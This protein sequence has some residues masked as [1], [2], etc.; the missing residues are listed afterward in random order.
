MKIALCMLRSEFTRMDGGGESTRQMVEALRCAGHEEITVLS[1]HGDH[2]LHR[3]YAAAE[4]SDSR[5]LGLTLR[6]C[7]AVIEL[8]RSQDVI[9]LILPNP[10]FGAVA[11][12]IH[13]RVQVPVAVVYESHWNSLA[14]YGFYGDNFSPGALARL[15]LLNRFTARLTLR[16]CEHYVVST[17]T[18]KSLLVGIGYDA[19]RVSVIPNCTTTAVPAR[20]HRE[21][22][23]RV[24]YLGHFNA[25]KGVDL[26]VQAMPRVVREHPDIE[27]HL[28]WSGSG[29]DHPRILRAIDS[30]GLATRTTVTDCRVDVPSFLGG[31]DVLVLPYRS[32]TRTRIIPSVLLEGLAVGVPIVTTSCMPITDVI[33][34]GTTGWVVPREDIDAMAAGILR[35]LDDPGYASQVSAAQRASAQRRF[36][37][38]AVGAAYT[39]LLGQLVAGRNPASASR[40]P[41]DVLDG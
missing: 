19:A 28:A 25:S 35:F 32:V 39:S 23:L 17:E 6:F 29:G 34:H 4:W 14:E 36:S 24:G 37:H 15:A 31:L 13:R 26:L 18:Q 33:E 1:S 9:F 10:S 12:W 16:A 5:A 27:L 7:A 40:R 11:D 41:A 30:L 3:S 21:R 20:P 38:E 8:S 22:P 2:P